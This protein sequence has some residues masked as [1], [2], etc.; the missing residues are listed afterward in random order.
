MHVARHVHVYAYTPAHAWTRVRTRVHARAASVSLDS[1]VLDADR[2]QG[3]VTC[4]S[5]MQP[6]AVH[7]QCYYAVSLLQIRFDI[8]FVICIYLYYVNIIM[9]SDQGDNLTSP[10]E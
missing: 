1:R 4:R 9:K 8:L 3:A 7:N 6:S 2:P 10:M 5:K